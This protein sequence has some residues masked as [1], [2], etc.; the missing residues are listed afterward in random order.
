MQYVMLELQIKEVQIKPQT[1]LTLISLFH[2]ELKT[3][4]QK[5]TLASFNQ[6][7]SSLKLIKKGG[8]FIYTLTLLVLLGANLR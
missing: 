3:F 6:T 7:S 5:L 4:V 8:Q 2:L 1:S